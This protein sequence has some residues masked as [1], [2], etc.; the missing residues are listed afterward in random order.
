M[1]CTTILSFDIETT[2][3]NPLA[4]IHTP[5]RNATV[6]CTFD[7][8]TQTVYHFCKPVCGNKKC[9]AAASSCIECE[10]A[11]M[12]NV[13]NFCYSLDQADYLCG[14]NIKEFDIPFLQACFQITDVDRIQSWKA[15]SIDPFLT[16]KE[17]WGIWCS[18]NKLLL[19]N[20][21]PAKTASGKEAIAMAN[22]GKWDQLAAYCMDDTVLTHRLIFDLQMI[23]VPIGGFHHGK[24]VFRFMT[25]DPQ[26]H[27]MVASPLLPSPIIQKTTRFSFFRSHTGTDS[28]N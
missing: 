11:Q 16:I 15:K 18:L 20:N 3:I 7:G 10:E 6:A 5:H 24:P 9:R 13:R 14:F 17:T 27:V 28:G 4:R 22:D 12:Q 2:G 26:N 1:S 8:H 19:C 25:Y 23:K 21:L